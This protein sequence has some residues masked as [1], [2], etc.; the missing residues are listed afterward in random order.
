MLL[1]CDSFDGLVEHILV[2][3]EFDLNNE[4]DSK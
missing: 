2:D 3:I 4:L 1:Y